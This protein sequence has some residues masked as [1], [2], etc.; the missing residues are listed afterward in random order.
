MDPKKEITF[1][2][3]GL[4][5]SDKDRLLSVLVLAEIRLD[6]GWVL[7]ELSEKNA[8]CFCGDVDKVL[9]EG[10]TGPVIQ[11]G[12]SAP[13]QP[14]KGQPGNLFHL[15][16]DAGN[17]PSFSSLIVILRRVEEWL[18]CEERPAPTPE[19]DAAVEEPVAAHEHVADAVPAVAAPEMDVAETAQPDVSQIPTLIPVV[20]DVVVE[21]PVPVSREELSQMPDMSMKLD[22]LDP[23]ADYL[24][25]QTEDALY[26]KVFLQSGEVILVDLEQGCFYST[27]EIEAFLSRS[28]KNKTSYTS[29]LD[30][31]GFMH[32][33][34]KQYYI[35]RPFSHLKWFLALYS[36]VHSMDIDTDTCSYLLTAW[37]GSELPGLHRDHLKLAAFMRA[38][39]ATPADIAAETGIGVDQI[40]SFVEAC[41]HEGLVHTDV[42]LD[43]THE[44]VPDKPKGLW[45]RMLNKIRR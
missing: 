30:R 7:H 42:E 11:Y 26:H 2:I 15:P 33:L 6:T 3:E 1:F 40:R 9:A 27:I 18:A 43:V 23:I 4:S 14:D 12:G 17:M 24:D 16:L 32:E 22:W 25:A 21:E 31:Q 34:E 45:G 29:A 35:K 36:N 41:Y 20:E 10:H 5:D 38:K 37:P 8:V 44:P 39:R 28:T 19:K 13:A